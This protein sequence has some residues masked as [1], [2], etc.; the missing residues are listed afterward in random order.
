MVYRTMGLA[1]RTMGPAEDSIEKLSESFVVRFGLYVHSSFLIPCR[2]PSQ[3]V[4]VI[5]VAVFPPKHVEFGLAAE[6]SHDRLA[7]IALG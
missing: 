5:S 7:S 1:Y 3:Q 2:Y 4:G 6:I